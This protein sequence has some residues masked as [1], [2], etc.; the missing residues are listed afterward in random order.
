MCLERPVLT[1]RDS[2]FAYKVVHKTED[3][4]YLPVF[5]VAAV[6]RKDKFWDTIYNGYPQ[7]YHALM[8]LGECVELLEEIMNKSGWWC[9]YT[10]NL[11]IV[12]VE[13]SGTIYR[14]KKMRYS[15]DDKIGYKAR[16]TYMLPYTVQDKLSQVAGTQQKI[17][18]EI[19][20]RSKVFLV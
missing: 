7:S 1:S 15:Y 2:V 18:F 14:E 8:S 11:V 5:A 12:A 4:D 3:G 16:R 20:Y 6:A 13:L 19:P 9:K 17:L 10:H